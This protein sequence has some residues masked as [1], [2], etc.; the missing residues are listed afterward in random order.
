MLYQAIKLHRAEHAARTTIHVWKVNM[1][2]PAFR[3]WCAMYIVRLMLHRMPLFSELSNEVIDS[4]AECVHTESFEKKEVLCQQGEVADK[5]FLIIEGLAQPKVVRDGFEITLP[6]LDFG[7]TFGAQALCMGIPHQHT[8]IGVDEVTCYVID[9]MLFVSLLGKEALL[10][11]VFDREVAE[12][13]AAAEEVIQTDLR[14]KRLSSEQRTKMKADALGSKF[15]IPDPSVHMLGF[16]ES[17]HVEEEKESDLQ[18]KLDAVLAEE[19]REFASM[20]RNNDGVLDRDEVMAAAH[21]V[22]D[23]FLLCLKL[24]LNRAAPHLDA[25]YS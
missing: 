12:A 18:A 13:A 17:G 19:A 2:R 25:L 22:S 14:E 21:T 16:F 20:D 1:I 9:S 5:F 7:A 4:L 10:R 3:H 24:C 6:L 15:V 11:E 8:I 23:L